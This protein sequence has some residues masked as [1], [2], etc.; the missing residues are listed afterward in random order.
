MQLDRIALADIYRPEPLAMAIHAQLGEIAPPIPVDQI[1]TA[2]DISEVRT[3]TFDGFEGMLLT[4]SRRSLGAILANNKHGARRARFT[5]AHELGHF[6][7]EHHV[8]T[9]ETGFQCR[10]ADMRETCESRREQKQETQANQFAISLLA[11]FRMVDGFLSEDPDL[12]DCQRMRDGLDVS[13]EASVRRMIDRRPELL[14]A[15]WSKDTRVR[16]VHR[17]KG[18]PY[19]PLKTHDPLPK[20][21]AAFRA[22]GNGQLGFT[23]PIETHPMAWTN[24]PEPDLFEQTRIGV[25]GHAVTLLWADSS[26][27]EDPDTDDD[28]GQRELGMLGFR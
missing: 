19:V 3:G 5:I 15:V 4:D 26:G 23:E 20:T 17:D 22:I 12:R 24:Q 8:L 1:A 2:L 25:D 13:L 28:P 11:P 21:T 10:A 16:Y 7:M 6:L 27:R 18:F 14:A 9:A